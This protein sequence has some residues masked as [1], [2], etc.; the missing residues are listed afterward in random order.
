MKYWL[1]GTIGLN[2]PVLEDIT[3]VAF[4]A[5]V[6]W[7]F[8]VIIFNPV[9]VFKNPYYI[10][11]FT[12]GERGVLYPHNEKVVTERTIDV[13]IGRLREKLMWDG[14]SELIET[15]RRMGYRFVAFQK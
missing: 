6:V 4:C 14:D 9:S 12:G 2:N 5:L 13:H 15:I 8:S 7:K 1:K 10:L 3:N 11:Y